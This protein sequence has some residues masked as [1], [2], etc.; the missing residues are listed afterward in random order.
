MLDLEGG[1]RTARTRDLSLGVPLAYDAVGV[2]TDGRRLVLLERGAALVADLEGD[3]PPLRVPLPPGVSRQAAF[4][5]DERVRLFHVTS[6]PGQ[7]GSLRLL[8][9]NLSSGTLTEAG[10]IETRSYALVRVSPDRSRILVLDRPERHPA[11]TLHAGDGTRLATLT[12]REWRSTCRPISWRTAVSRSCRA[13]PPRAF[14]SCRPTAPANARSSWPRDLRSRV[15]A[16]RPRRASSPSAWVSSDGQ[17]RETVLV[18]AGEARVVRRY[19]DLSPAATPWFAWGDAGARP[20][21]ASPATHLFL[22]MSGEAFTL[23]L[24][25]GARRAVFPRAR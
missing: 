3:R 7:A 11:L 20:A 18:D 4:L 5:D 21:P 6:T 25:T 17:Q 14:A 22:D 15:S 24:A 10:H 19:P 1:T 23:D 9:V 16:R 8:D 13:V 2:V 12:K